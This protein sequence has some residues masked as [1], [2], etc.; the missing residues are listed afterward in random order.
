MTFPILCL[1][2]VPGSHPGYRIIF[3]RHIFLSSSWLRQFLRFSCC[4][5]PWQFW[6]VLIR[7]VTECLSTGACLELWVLGKEV[8]EVKGH[9]ISRVQLST[10][11]ITLDVNLWGMLSGV[12]TVNL[13]SPPP[14]PSCTLWKD[15]VMHSPRFGIWKLCSVSLKMECWCELFRILLSGRAIFHLFL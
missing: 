10:R 4:R 8:T 1:F 15:A 7:H 5:W 6:G 11:L 13:L 9:P 2:Y 12:C 14:F 3:S